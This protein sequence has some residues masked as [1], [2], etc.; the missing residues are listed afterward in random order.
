MK[1]ILIIPAV[2]LI[3]GT[4]FLS[5]CGN[6]GTDSAMKS[7]TLNTVDSANKKENKEKNESEEKEGKE[8]D[9]TNQWQSR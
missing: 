8:N 1:K 5:A 3:M 7:P 6:S 9:E 4:M 2:L